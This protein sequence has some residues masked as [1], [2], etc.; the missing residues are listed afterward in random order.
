MT[1]ATE[2]YREAAAPV[3]LL[4]FSPPRSADPSAFDRLV[5]VDA[6]L[7]GAAYNPGRSVR[8][9]SVTAAWVAKQ[10]TGREGVFNL[11]TRDMNKIAIQSRLLGAQ[12]MGIDNVVVLRGDPLSSRETGNGVSAVHDYSTL[13]LLRDIEALNQGLDYRG[14]KLQAPTSLC[15]G[16]GIDLERDYSTEAAWA[17]KKVDAG[18]AFFMTQPVYDPAQRSGFLDRYQEVTGGPLRTPVFW[19]V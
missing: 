5:G 12:A 13:A 3:F 2:I 17:A 14:G 15:A 10:R 4:D 1:H 8:V 16:A 9:D 6:D 19:G 11:S 18:A 7:M